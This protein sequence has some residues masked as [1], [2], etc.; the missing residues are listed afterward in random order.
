MELAQYAHIP[1]ASF[2]TDW[3]IHTCDVF[4]ARALREAGHLLWVRALWH[5]P[6]GFMTKT[7]V[8][9]VLSPRT[10]LHRILSVL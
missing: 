5:S 4:Y 8:T 1:L 3:M 9:G 6:L 10:F 2:E 7:G